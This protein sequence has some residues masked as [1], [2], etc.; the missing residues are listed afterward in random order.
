MRPA[1]YFDR[2]T[3][4]ELSAMEALSDGVLKD[5]VSMWVRMTARDGA[6]RFSDARSYWDQHRP[7]FRVL[8]NNLGRQAIADAHAA[9]VHDLENA[10]T[11]AN[12][13]RLGGRGD[14][15]ATPTNGAD[16]T[17][18]SPLPERLAELE[19][20]IS[21]ALTNTTSASDLADLLR[22]NEL[23]VVAAEEFARA[24]HEAALDPTV[25]PD[26]HA[27]RQRAED[28]AFAANRLKT[29]GPR[30]F[31]HF[32]KIYAQEQVQT[33]VVKFRELA[34]ER[35]ALAAELRATYRDAA[36]KLVDL[37]T[38]VR[39][40]EQRARQALDVVKSLHVVAMVGGDGVRLQDRNHAR[41]RR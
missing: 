3:G 37:F 10:R 40:F 5:G 18:E 35:D 7:G 30:L 26:P 21:A 11:P 12:S 33:Y 36:D 29:L 41:Q 39:A 38:R 20:R 2:R 22:Q 14:G 13:A 9:Y 1:Q 34:P 4:R 32:Q 24:E 8:D 23:A 19:R 6:P 25:S 27:A 31:A 16:V 15:E 28:A 17:I